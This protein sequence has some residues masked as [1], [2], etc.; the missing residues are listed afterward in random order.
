MRKRK[1][2]TEIGHKN[3]TNRGQD[4]DREGGRKK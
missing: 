1:Y 3:E 4:R 2:E